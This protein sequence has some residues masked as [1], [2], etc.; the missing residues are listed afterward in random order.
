LHIVI[1]MRLLRSPILLSLAP[2][3]TFCTKS[4]ALNLTPSAMIPSTCTTNI[5]YL[6]AEKAQLIDD[7]L[8]S[9]DIGFSIDQLME[10]AGLSV[11]VAVND[12]LGA[13]NRKVLILAGPGN[14]GGDGLVAARHLTHFGHEPTII[15]PKFK[16]KLFANLKAQCESLDITIKDSM[17]PASI[18][19]SSFDLILDSLFG[20]SFKGPAR[21]PYATMM[22]SFF[23]SGT[24]VLSV[25]VPSGW[26]VEDGDTWNTY[27]IPDAVISL[28]LP[29]N[30]MKDYTGVHYLG[31]RFMPKKLAVELDLKIPDYGPSPTQI[32][33]LT[34]EIVISDLI[35]PEFLAV[36]I[37]APSMDVAKMLSKGLLEKK[38]VAC[39][40]VTPK[41]VSLYTWKG[42]M[43]EEDEVLMMCKTQ[44]KHIRALT[45]FVNEN[46]P[47]DVAEVISVPLD[48]E[49]ANKQYMNWVKE[50]TD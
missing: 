45:T 13:P 15:Y 49:R 48:A 3:S 9:E 47:Y 1:H 28:T 39:V 14:N 20:F 2:F 29:K 50:V 16:G 44:A 8:M 10:L 42:K 31:G 6:N 30:C 11:A 34:D 22:S 4:L 19:T 33:K 18:E 5:S 35:E 38:L 7:R 40:N 41:V 17:D 23:G 43:E 21:E 36:Y 32:V 26:H 46:H 27:F 37:T 25:D 24:P 12:F